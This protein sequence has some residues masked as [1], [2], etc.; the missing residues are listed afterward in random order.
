MVKIND[1]DQYVEWTRGLVLITKSDTWS[2]SLTIFIWDYSFSPVPFKMSLNDQFVVV[3]VARKSRKTLEKVVVQTPLKAV[4]SSWP[5]FCRKKTYFEIPSAKFDKKFSLQALFSRLSGSTKLSCSMSPETLPMAKLKS[6]LREAPS[7]Q[8]RLTMRHPWS[9]ECGGVSAFGTTSNV[10]KR[11]WSHKWSKGPL[12]RISLSHYS[13]ISRGDPK[14]AHV[15][16][17]V[18]P[19]SVLTKRPFS[20]LEFG[21]DDDGELIDNIV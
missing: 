16:V 7:T 1:Q 3:F 12:E 17:R 10:G 19:L 4:R 11:Q 9:I 18:R 15:C 21:S 2:L 13:V 6:D 8:D 5:T 14:C 20:C